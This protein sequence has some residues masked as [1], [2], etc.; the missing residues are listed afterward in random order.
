MLP[1]RIEVISQRMAA[2]ELGFRIDIP[3][4]VALLNG[5]Q[6]IANRIFTGLVLTGLLI[7]S[8][9]LMPYRRGLGT[10]GFIISGAL[11][12]YM[13]GSILINDRRKPRP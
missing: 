13:I 4:V 3:Q 7:A 1:R 10:T 6:K 8:A 2:N 11:G 12:V 9:M 5:M